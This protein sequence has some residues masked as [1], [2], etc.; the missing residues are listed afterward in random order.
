MIVF[1]C[2]DDFYSILCGIYDAWMSR[3]DMKM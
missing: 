3:G 2:R 1:V